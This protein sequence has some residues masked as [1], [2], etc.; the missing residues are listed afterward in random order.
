MPQLQ[1][2]NH[3]TNIRTLG[4]LLAWD[5]KNA[6]DSYKTANAEKLKNQFLKAGY[7]MRPLGK[8]FYLMPPYCIR[9]LSVHL[10]NILKIFS[11]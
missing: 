10:F 6:G 7:N 2:C 3:I 5:L 9:M 11:D 1:N 8:T 4:T